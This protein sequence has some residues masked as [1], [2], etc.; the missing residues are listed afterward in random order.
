MSVE[1]TTSPVIADEAAV[2]A[3]LT[4]ILRALLEDYEPDDIEITRDTTFH[5]DL[6]LESIDLV[7]MSAQLREKYGEAIN[8]ASFVADLELGQIMALTVGE[9]VDFV[10]TSLNAKGKSGA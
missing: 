5:D 10:V 1:E 6:E 9:L 4:G 8:F 2:L 3:D 7:A